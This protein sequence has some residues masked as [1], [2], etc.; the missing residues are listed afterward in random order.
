MELIKVFITEDESIV[1]EGLRDIIP[2]EKYG[3]EFVG[4]APD[5]EMAL[6]MIRK[7][8][9][10]VL[11]TDIKMPFMDGLSLSNIVSRE[12]PD[13]KIIIISGYS[14]FEYARQAIELNVDQYLLKPITK[15]AMIKA[16]ELTRQKIEEEQEQKDFLIRYEQESKKYESFSRRAFF[17]TLV[18]GSLTVQQIYEQA[19]KLNLDLNA[20]GYNFVIF[21]VQAIN[22]TSYSEPAAV[23]LDELLNYFLRYP[24]YIL[25]RCNLL[26]YALLVKGDADNLE[27]LTQRSI[28][29]IQ[30][31][32]RESETP[33][34]W[35]VAVGSPTYRLSGL[36]RCY[37]DTNHVL[38]YRHLMP[39]KHVFTAEILKAER[40]Q[41]TAKN[42][43]A[44]D[45]VKVDPMVIRNFIQTGTSEETGAFVEE[46][47]SNLGGVE[48]SV[49]FRHYLIISARI[50][51]ELVLQ[52]M[53]CA[54]E[55][56]VRRIPQAEINMPVENLKDY[57]MSVFRTAVEMRDLEA[58]R[59]NS[60]IIDSAIK[61]IDK[62][63]ADENISLNS[64]AQA[65]NISANYLSALF[66]QK[67]GISFVE[68]LTQKRM[69]RARQLLRRSG[70]RSGEI[71]Y[72][73]GYKDPRYF[74]FV[75]K[76]T[77]GC[78]PRSYR[79]GEIDKE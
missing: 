47:I 56:Y 61:Y 32:C 43:D 18:E 41:G 6:P 73:V 14:D 38:A 71:A 45:I 35:Y 20:D 7:L 51:A 8:K 59:Q 36:P 13:T 75:F 67:M 25:F 53:G 54:K 39:S 40:E 21:T 4:D 26:S 30:N 79:T 19:D 58:Q 23:I 78:T 33:L 77:Q 72:E 60:D 12:L 29:I 69:L 24:D 48:R 2:W 1:R 28:D 10:N 52:E 74:S 46:Y 55:E 44:L 42:L 65:I 15:A 50:N 16:L 64:V 70:K 17:E 34:N 11:I 5:G 68:Y 27:E 49:L 3:F 22:E 57:L 66:S 37:A 63:Y 31:R 76:K 9:P 62:N